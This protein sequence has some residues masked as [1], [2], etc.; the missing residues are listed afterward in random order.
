MKTLFW[1]SYGVLWVLAVL[2][3]VAVL[4]IYRQFGLMLIPGSRRADLAGLDI[5]AKA[6]P[7]A[8]DFF[9]DARPSVLT[10]DPSELKKS[11]AGW[12]VL[13]ASPT[14][15]ICESIW[16]GGHALREVASSWPDVEFIWIDARWRASEPPRG[17]LMAVSEDHLAS[18]AMD[19]PVFPF[20]YAITA[21]GEVAAK[22]LVNEPEHL[23]LLAGEAFGRNRGIT[24]DDGSEAL[25]QPEQI[26]RMEVDA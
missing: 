18:D 19:V 13:F 22:R 9:Q 4:L 21:G 12:V 10:W 17:W 15:S 5:G 1:T 20:A 2:L 6:P 24:G 23:G 25:A 8:L 7:L 14:C 16:K 11:Q 3:V 26:R